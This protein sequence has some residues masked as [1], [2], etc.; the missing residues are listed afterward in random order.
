MNTMRMNCK[1]FNGLMAAGMLALG[2][3]HAETGVT[4]VVDGVTTNVG[5]SCYVGNTGPF[6][7]L[8][9]TNAGLLNV[10]SFSY[11][12]KEVDASNNSVLVT[13]PGSLWMARNAIF[14]GFS[15][16]GNQLTVRDGAQVS[17]IVDTTATMIGDQ[18][19]AANNSLVITGPGSSFNLM[20]RTDS[21]A[22]RL[23]VGS[24]GPGNS[25]TVSDGGQM[26]LTAATNSQFTLGSSGANNTLTVSGANSL[27]ALQAPYGTLYISSTGNQMTV[28]SGG[29]VSNTTGYIGYNSAAN[30]NA[31]T[32]QGAGARWNNSGT[33]RIGNGTDS[34]GNSLTITNGGLVVNAEGDI[35]YNNGANNNRVLVSDPG[36]I[37]SNNGKI[38]V[39]YLGAG[40]SLIVTNGGVVTASGYVQNGVGNTNNHILV[41]GPGSA[42]KSAQGLYANNAMT[43]ADGGLVENTVG[44]I[45]GPSNSVLVTGSGSVWSNSSTLTIGH[46]YQYNT[47]TIS[48]GA[49]VYDAGAILGD[50][51]DNA[52]ALV[53]GAG[54]LWRHAGNVEFNGGY[55]TLTLAD[56]GA[57]IVGSNISFNATSAL[58]VECDGAGPYPVLN[59][60]GTAQLAGTL[61]VTNPP[62]FTPA[63]SNAYTILKAASVTGQFA[64]TNLT[65]LG[66]GMRWRVLI[67][68]TSVVAQAISDTATPTVTTAPVSNVTHSA[69]QSGGT[70]TTVEGG[71]PVTAR[72][73]CWNLGGTPTIADSHTTDGSGTGSFASQ[74]TG[75]TPSQ[76]YHVRAYATSAA[77][78]GYGADRTCTTLV[79]PP[80]NALSFNGTNQSVNIGHGASLN[81]GNT[82]TVEAWVKPSNVTNRYAVFS[83]RLNNTAGSF[84]LEIGAGSGTVGTD[85][86]RVGVSGVGTWV[87]QAT[88]DV[89]RSNVWTHIAYTRTGTGAGTH[90][91]YV[92][93][94]AQA[95][96]SNDPYTFTNNASDKMIGSGTLGGQFFPGQIDELRVWNVARTEAE[97]R[98]A[99]HKPLA[100]SESGLV[101]YYQFNANS[102]T[103]LADLTANANTG[104]LSNSPAWAAS[105]F[106]SASLITDRTNLRGA[107][108]A[109]TNSLASSRLTVTNA[110]A[111]GT[112]F[113]VF[114]HDNGADAWQASDLPSGL[115]SRLTRV[116]RAEVSGSASGDLTFDTTGLSGVG[117][118]AGLRLLADAD[119]TFASG[120]TALTGTYS[121]PYF[122]VAGQTLASGTYYTL[123]VIPIHTVTATAGA[124]GTLDGSTP[125]PANVPDNATVSFKFNA[126][127]GYH[128]ASVTGCGISYS[129]TADTVTTYTA[130][131]GPITGDGAVTATFAIN[132]FTTSAAGLPALKGARMGG[133][134]IGDYDR[135]GKQDI[136]LAGILDGTSTKIT[137]IYR[138][139]GDGTYTDS[140]VS[141]PGVHRG[142][143]AWGDYDNDGYLDFVMAG[144]MSDTTT[145]ITRIYHN[146][147]DGT[148]TDINAGL[149]AVIYSSMAWGDY[150][151]DGRLDL[152][153][154]GSFYSYSDGALSSSL[155]TRI[156]H[157]DGNGV[158][159]D[160]GVSL[161]GLEQGAVAWGD[162][163]NDGKLDFVLTGYNA[164]NYFAR[165]YHNNGDGTFT[166][167]N[168]GLPGVK[169]SSVAW[170]DYDNDGY[171]DLVLNGTTNYLSDN[172]GAISRIY[173]NNGNGTFSDI[174]AGLTGS[175]RGG[176]AWGDY[177]NDGRL[178]LALSG[179]SAVGDKFLLY[180]NNGDNT[181]GFIET[182]LK[183]SLTS[184]LYPDFAGWSDIDID[185]RLDL[186]LIQGNTLTSSRIFH[187]NGATTLITP[188]AAPGSLTATISNGAVVFSWGAAS[189]SQTPADGL[190]YNL[191]VG[192]AP[193]T[194]DI[195]SGMANTTNGCRY[196]PALG[197][198]GK[199][200][201]R[202]LTLPQG[203]TYYWSVQAIDTSYAGGAW[204]AEASVAVPNLPVIT[205][206]SLTNITA[207]GAQG[208]GNVV[209]AGDAPVTARG[210]CWNTSGTPTRADPGTANGSGI[211]A[212]TGT[213][214][215]LTEGQ[216]Y[217]V[218]AWAATASDTVYGSQRSFVARAPSTLLPPGNALVFNG[219]SQYVVIPSASDLELNDSQ[220]FELWF[221]PASVTGVQGLLSKQSSAAA[222]GWYLR[223]NGTEIEFNGQTTAGLG[224]AAGYWYHLA[225]VKS[226]NSQTLYIYGTSM[227]L[228]GTRQELYYKGDP[229]RIGSDLGGSYFN[230]RMDEVRI[231]NTA[232]SQ[233]EVRENMHLVQSGTE[234]G[235]VAYYTFN[236]R[237]G[238]TL[239]ERAQSAWQH[240]GTL[241]GMTGGERAPSTISAGT[242]SANS[243]AEALGTVT[244][245]G[246]GL[247]A[248][249][250]EVGTANITTTR[251]EAGP[252]NL[253][254]GSNKTQLAPWWSVDRLDASGS[255]SA[256]LT[257]TVS[258]G[259]TAADEATPANVSLYRRGSVSETAW[260]FVGTASSVSAANQTATFDNISNF[261]QFAVV[262]SAALMT[263]VDTAITGL[264][265]GN[266]GYGQ[267]NRPLVWG[268]FNNDGRQD[269]AIIINVDTT[270]IFRRNADGSF[271]DIGVSLPGS[272]N[273]N[274]ACA[275]YDNDGWLDLAIIGSASRK[276]Y[277][278][279]NNHDDT[280]TLAATLDIGCGTGYYYNGN[281][282]WG[283]YNNDGRP[284]LLISTD[285]WGVGMK[286]AIYRNDG[287]GV[288][289]EINAGLP[290][291]SRSHA[292]WGDF[293]N[294]GR[295]DIVVVDV[296]G[297]KI[298]HN[299]GPDSGGVYSFTASATMTASIDYNNVAIGDYDN[300]GYLDLAIT[301]SSSS[302][303]LR[304]YHNN[305]DGSFTDINASLPSYNN[306]INIEWGDYD[307]D[308]RLDLLYSTGYNSSGANKVMVYRNNGNNTF[309]DIT[310]NLAANPVP[311]TAPYT[312]YAAW[313]DY[314]GD[315][316]LDIAMLQ[317]DATFIYRNTTVNPAN[318]LP[319]APGGLS[320]TVSEGVVTLSW[321]A[322]SDSQ[323]PADGLTYNL[324]VGTGP[325]KDDVFSGLANTTSGFRKVA[326]LGN[327]QMNR[328]WKLTLLG[329]GIFYWSVQAVDTAFAGSAWAAEGTF[330]DPTP[331]VATAPVSSITPTSAICGGEV[332]FEGDAPVTARGCVW[333]TTGAPAIEAGSHDGITT[334]GAGLGT[335]TISLTGTGGLTCYVRA[336][337]TSAQG[338]RY[339]ALRVFSFPMT[340]PGNALSGNVGNSG[341]VSIADAND[342]D[343]TSNYTLETWFK[344]E[345]LGAAGDL[346]GL[347]GKYQ[348]SGSS[349]YLLRLNGTEL[350]FD[351]MKTTNLNLQVGQWYHVAAVNDNGTRHLYVNGVEKTIAGT[352][353]VVAANTDELRLFS[354]FGG[355][356][357]TGQMDETRIWNVVRSPADIQDAMHR[358][359][360]GSE[361]GLAAYYKFN[362]ASGTLLIDVTGKGHEGTLMNGPEWVASTIPCANAIAS[363]T[364]LR[365]TWIA[366]T[367]S[368]ASSRLSVVNSS[369]TGTDFAV[370]GHDNTSDN[371]QTA[372]A[373]AGVNSRLTRVWRAEVSGSA[374]GTIKIDTTGLS[375]IGDGSTLRL[376]VDADGTFANAIVVTGTYSAPYFTAAG[377]TIASG[378]YYT[379]GGNF[380]TDGDT[381]PNEWE[382]LYYGGTTNANPDALASNGVNTVRE[383]YIADLNPTNPASY[384]R[385]TAVSNQSPWTVYFEASAD[386]AYTLLGVSNLV[387][388]VWTNVPGAGPR[389]GTGGADSMQDTNVPPKG[390]FYRM[391]VELP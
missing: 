270:K 250:T 34:S 164:P 264:P 309:T 68:S 257:F 201:S 82:L 36:S 168:A 219:S 72:G 94:V 157:N 321:N 252:P 136:L 355:R 352:A 294:D 287:G 180:R 244:F 29:A 28:S 81:V 271:T 167:I 64:A 39:G 369:E 268:D 345:S 46:T 314:D 185:G 5:G 152:I 177:D 317:S 293:D 113:V 228:S 325:G 181:F 225:A 261:G 366:N 216:T 106:P 120:A 310:G 376:L 87:A 130:T 363:L 190:S 276:T 285:N 379:L 354:D 372:D 374:T 53:T 204:A 195:Y 209:S 42:L 85:R 200:R 179:S 218:R 265:G 189:D 153:L 306:G 31:V 90:A 322:A 8:I 138:N 112:N 131:T 74:I 311:N 165:I 387:S 61:S 9:I 335:F 95:L 176:C 267:V 133:A 197:N 326:A 186:V 114:G 104:T 207:T 148:F 69:A 308:G 205:T 15:G 290:E 17:N 371:W 102:G 330:H 13:G 233:Q 288:F 44:M 135:D 14:L 391:K 122:T 71:S 118:G 348:T 202:T 127:S 171:F 41:T 111:T 55:A 183:A 222:Q 30:S 140:G 103:A 117:T 284:D 38:L 107:W 184:T 198:M 187:N 128:V 121:A 12:G 253:A 67:S 151:N 315:G 282:A 16:A 88:N 278:Y 375:S 194:D 390:P 327:V 358:E 248:N 96:I 331:V 110:V 277:V 349:G 328:S 124:N 344:A 35:G 223:L 212:F 142:A 246:V 272:R 320:A 213:L 295:L 18:A 108:L 115:S 65:S 173:R 239:C 76:T 241:T 337:A 254:P 75:L 139:N 193:G 77:G 57:M 73:V 109:Q 217:Y 19:S 23:F 80:G 255:F 385:I 221:K 286:T 347:I 333:N 143:V 227:P 350:D 274:I 156:Y 329:G 182:G 336:Y 21:Y 243:Q 237:S 54:S 383:A 206:A 377:Q 3:A 386:R 32:V 196:V 58:S 52:S 101:A 160:S 313:G 45:D 188:P 105:T 98:D 48:D 381:L 158:F 259:L 291:P 266:V 364:N 303:G 33:L 292:L 370:F 24:Y 359:L 318:T 129:N 242:G 236:E 51:N 91:L 360:T 49:A 147:G 240:P 357:L 134:S 10:T 340:P 367:N 235:L 283:D 208:G 159:S 27:L 299:N 382:A 339:G 332:T 300:D 47:L 174:N 60:N 123:G 302:F 43:I 126:N 97:L 116:W 4:N 2:A 224:L 70:V 365:G 145:Y 319:T 230:G 353:I 368:L 22:A 229:L 251:I 214:T 37:W 150:D 231:W 373:P 262:R 50:A 388:G 232:R 100:G 26:I 89:I 362:Q 296:G 341:Y 269:I 203:Q 79:A 380:D 141:L 378:T 273:G 301:S 307:N 312:G 1:R 92:N 20:G 234:T 56:G 175:L 238:T 256:S 305:G 280:F 155:I 192:T 162:Y 338:T 346:R 78:T 178:D 132:Y 84:Q 199:N 25:V 324:R 281:V 59:V 298:Y 63:L 279:R 169:N 297:T 191:R 154:S 226:G 99:M 163:D 260:E 166:D 170:G 275:D 86:G 40:N 83:T 384:F 334:N 323:T 215:G 351:Q 343:M 172:A 245:S 66:G 93:G 289:T 161:P 6:N 7:A 247:T 316:K 356:Y 361:S 211:G 62:G 119:G 249:Y 137:R 11:I 304:I 263:R 258:Q 210:L 149:P 146:N 342:L 220:T 144:E 125:S 389:L